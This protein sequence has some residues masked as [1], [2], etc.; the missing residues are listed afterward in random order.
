MNKTPSP[1]SGSSH[2]RTH[3]SQCSVMNVQGSFRMK[4]C[5]CN[6]KCVWN[7]MWSCLQSPSHWQWGPVHSGPEL[8]GFLLASSL[9][10]GQSRLTGAFLPQTPHHL[11]SHTVW[12]RV[13]TGN[14]S[15]NLILS[16]MKFVTL[17]K[18][19][20]AEA[21]AGT[22]LLLIMLFSDGVKMK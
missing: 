19:L 16:D 7:C 1:A 10:L 13:K 6:K 14:I 4:F 2:T 22:T 21:V 5:G 20:G 11:C 12:S 9:A 17:G 18:Q 15:T 3:T 8:S